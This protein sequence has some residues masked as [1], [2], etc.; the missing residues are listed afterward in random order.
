M[1]RFFAFCTV[2]AIAALC[3]FGGCGCTKKEKFVFPAT[4]EE[5]YTRVYTLAGDKP[6]DFDALSVFS[7]RQTLTLTIPELA[8]L[9]DDAGRNAYPMTESRIYWLDARDKSHIKSQVTD[10]LVTYNTTAGYKYTVPTYLN[11]VRQVFHTDTLS[12]PLLD[13]TGKQLDT[14]VYPTVFS[15]YASYRLDRQ[16]FDAQM[17]TIVPYSLELFETFGGNVSGDVFLIG[18]TVKTERFEDFFDCFASAYGFR[19]W[20]TQAAG[21]DRDTRIYTHFLDPRFFRSVHV[22]ITTAKEGL[23]SVTVTIEADAA[24]PMPLYEVGE[25]TLVAT[26]VYS[27]AASS[28]GTI[29]AP[30]YLAV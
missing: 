22:D 4:A 14:A 6:F 7:A 16:S 30:K 29:T 25:L 26:T 8:A 15:S 27:T 18:G 11:P 20:Y 2:F 19:E 21:G 13:F 24:S 5:E 3:A 10:A 28:I 17:Q 12:R 23:R 9:Q 1:K